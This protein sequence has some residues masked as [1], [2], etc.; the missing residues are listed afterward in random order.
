MSPGGGYG[1]LGPV[2]APVYF[3]PYR[4][5]E[6]LG[7]GGMC[8]VFRARRDGAEGDCA[9][10][11]LKDEWKTDARVRDMFMTEADVSM[12]IEHPN[13]VHAHDAGEVMGRPFIELELIEGGNLGDLSEKCAE[14]HLPLPFDTSM[15]IVSELLDGL[16]ALHESKSRA[17]TPL[18]LVHRDVSPHN[19]FLSFDGRVILGDFGVAHIQ[20]YGSSDDAH[21]LGKFGY[22]APEMAQGE[23]VDRKAD[24]FSAGIILYELLT[25]HAPFDAGNDQEALAQAV[26]AKFPRPSRFVS[27][28]PRELESVILK[29]TARR[30]RDR[31]ETGEEFLLELEPYWS[32]QLANPFALQG[33]LA[34]V[35]PN[36]AHSWWARRRQ[37]I[38][39]IASG[40]PSG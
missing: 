25:G 29:A 35:R 1:R 4:V 11:V 7:Q 34:A 15:Y 12:M 5:L 8:H 18:G 33:L 32:K 26:E 39:G 40:W 13:L 19:V 27:S 21:P 30:P 16:H 17:G 9:L 38:R 22:L 10:K 20:A 2:G 31:F 23:E 24:I 37:P 36:E 14:L 28:M 3:G 6:R